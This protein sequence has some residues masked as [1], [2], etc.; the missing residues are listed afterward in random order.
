MK[1]I[2]QCHRAYMKTLEGSNE[3]ISTREVD[4]EVGIGQAQRNSQQEAHTQLNSLQ[5]DSILAR[6]G[7]IYSHTT[8]EYKVL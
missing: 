2:E 6:G 7:T 4:R 8:V 1:H 3:S 5:S